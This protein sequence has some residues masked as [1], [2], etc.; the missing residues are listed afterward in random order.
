[1]LGQTFTH[2]LQVGDLALTI[3]QDPDSQPCDSNHVF[4]R[5]QPNFSL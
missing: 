2:Q 5:S 3:P 4:I 1:M